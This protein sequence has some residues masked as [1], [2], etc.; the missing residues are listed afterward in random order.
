MPRKRPR[1]RRPP[2]SRPRTIPPP[3]TPPPAQRE[4][5]TKRRGELA[6]LAFTL[7]ATGLGFAVSKPYGDSE[8]YD[9][10][11]DPRELNPEPSPK[12]CHPERSQPESEANRR[13]QSKACP[14]P[15]EGD[16]VP[17]GTTSGPEG[18]SHYPATAPLWRV[19]VK[20]STQLLNGLYRIN[21][22]RRI[23]GRAVPY[24]PSEIDFFAAYIIPEDTWY[25]LPLAATH[26]VTSLLFRRQRDPKPGL[27]DPYREA[28]HLLRP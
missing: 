14:E 12:K 10:I 9:F 5:I 21:A 28:W 22:H 11:L 25:I 19:Q 18:S 26:G 13:A 20:C 8:R 24:L 15:A 7:K 23:N 4:L 2:A 3:T 16:P 1:T 27:Y 17:A 6:E